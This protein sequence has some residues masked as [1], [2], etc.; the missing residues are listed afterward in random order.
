MEWILEAVDYIPALI[1]YIAPGYVFLA[2]YRFFRRQY[3]DESDIRQKETV[4]ISVCISFFMK[5]VVD[6]IFAHSNTNRPVFSVSLIVAGAV[7]GFLAAKMI[8]GRPGS[9]LLDVTGAG[10][11]QNTNIWDDIIEPDLWVRVW[12]KDSGASY[13]G[14]VRY[15]EQK[16]REPVICMEHYQYINEKEELVIDHTSDDKR[17]VILNLKDF[18]RIET[19]IR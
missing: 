1:T 6:L 16:A 14:Q 5:A 12:L 7:L 18:D 4:L 11:T 13:Y 8:N 15:Y 17:S 19:A 3:Y 2:M 10:R 9:W